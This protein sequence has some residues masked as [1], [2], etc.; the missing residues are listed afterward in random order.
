MKTPTLAIVCLLLTANYAQAQ[1]LA[2]DRSTESLRGLNG[3]GLT[4]Y[5]GRGEPLDA[6]QQATVIKALLDDAKEKF[7]DTGIP[8]FLTAQPI[9]NAPGSPQLFIKIA[10]NRLNGYPDNPSG[11]PPMI[12]DAWL[13]QTAYLSR[14]TSIQLSLSTWETHA[15]GWFELNNGKSFQ[16]TIDWF[17]RIIAIQVK[18]FIEAYR[19]ANP[20][21]A[22]HS[23]P[24]SRRLSR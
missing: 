16:A 22:N 15:I 6:N 11:V 8:L 4:I 9:M 5:F 18:Q 23:A 12:S 1:S 17:R 13:T 7:A 3:I 24:M 21:Y 10:L 14:D 2:H 20:K 19:V